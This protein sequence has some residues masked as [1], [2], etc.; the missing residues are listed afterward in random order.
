MKHVISFLW[1][2]V[3]SATTHAKSSLPR[4]VFS[5]EPAHLRIVIDHLTPQHVKGEVLSYKLLHVPQE[6]PVRLDADMNLSGGH[7][8]WDSRNERCQFDLDLDIK[9]SGPT[10]VKLAWQEDSVVLNDL[11]IV[12]GKTTTVRY[13]G[14]TGKTRFSGPFAKLNA[15]LHQHLSYNDNGTIVRYPVK[16]LS[17][18]STELPPQQYWAEMGRRILQTMEQ[19]AQKG[20]SKQYCEILQV[21]LDA[22]KIKL[23]IG[24]I[25]G[26]SPE[27]RLKPICSLMTG[28]NPFSTHACF[29]GWPVDNSIWIPKSYQVL[30]SFAWDDD[31][32]VCNDVLDVMAAYD[33]MIGCLNYGKA[34]NEKELRNALYAHHDLYVNYVQ[35]RVEEHKEILERSKKQ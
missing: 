24:R 27:L 2:L 29:Y 26:N 28:T 22:E 10:Q 33:M 6:F 25:K 32:P 9:C 13:D 12:P 3:L 11:I 34:Y 31:T 30:R 19:A 5:D 20:R 35:R 18:I 23:M 8:T 4:P 21:A 16:Q 17:D 14:R 15:E 1:L 7:G